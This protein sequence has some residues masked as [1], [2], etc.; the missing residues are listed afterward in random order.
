MKKD[1]YLVILTKE[2]LDKVQGDF[3]HTKITG[4]ISRH[5]IHYWDEISEDVTSNFIQ[6][7][8]HYFCDKNKGK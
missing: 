6:F 7:F 2:Q 5:I 3:Y 1:Y 4:K 8:F